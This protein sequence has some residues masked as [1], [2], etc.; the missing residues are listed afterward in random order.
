MASLNVLRGGGHRILSI[1]MRHSEL[2]TLA[3]LLGLQEVGVLAHIR[4]ENLH[5]LS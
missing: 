4:A 5:R 1:V 2:P 3:V